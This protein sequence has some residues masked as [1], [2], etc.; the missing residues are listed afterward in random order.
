MDNSNYLHFILNKVFIHSVRRINLRYLYFLSLT[1]FFV[2]IFFTQFS[3]NNII[4][5]FSL[6]YAQN[7]KN[8]GLT[9]SPIIYKDTVGNGDNGTLEFHIRNNNSYQISLSVLFND[10]RPLNDSGVPQYFSQANPSD[11]YPSSWFSVLSSKSSLNMQPYSS[12]IVDVSVKVPSSAYVGDHYAGI[13]FSY[14]SEATSG[15][16]QINIKSEIA[17]PVIITVPGKYVYNTEVLGIDI[18]KIMNIFYVPGIQSTCLNCTGSVG[19]NIQNN[20]N[21]FIEPN[22]FFTVGNKN[23][24]FNP[25]LEDILVSQRRIITSQFSVYGFNGFYTVLTGSFTAGNVA[26]NVKENI[27][28]IN[29]LYVLVFLFISLLIY[30]IF[31][32]FAFFGRGSIKRI[33]NRV[34]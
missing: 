5:G 2:T 7:T 9:V 21:V 26:K 28:I 6:V 10:F 17:V 34:R 24:E 15:M 19:L 30:E 25:Q 20:G 23:Y 22:G 27:I 18:P 3:F 33:N 8:Q 32:I 29:W 13:N 31:K 4:Q 14:L 16:S 11:E 1:F 12:T